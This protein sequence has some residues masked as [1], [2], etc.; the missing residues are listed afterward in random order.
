MWLGGG[1]RGDRMGSDEFMS[2]SLPLMC[3]RCKAFAAPQNVPEQPK[4]FVRKEGLPA[5]A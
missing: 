4:V 3:E 1:G 5:F 2:M